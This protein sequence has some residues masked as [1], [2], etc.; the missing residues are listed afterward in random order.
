MNLA[1]EANQVSV[2]QIS[3]IAGQLNSMFLAI[4]NTVRL[5]TRAMYAQVEA[6]RS[7]QEIVLINED[8]KREFQFWISQVD[9]L[10]GKAMWF[11]SSAVRVAYSDASDT[12]YGGYI[13]ELGPNVAA[14]GTWNEIE[15]SQSSA[16]RELI[17]VRN[18]LQSFSSKISGLTVKWFTDNQNVARI[19]EVGSGK[20]HLQ[21]EAL[22]IFYICSSSGITIEPA[23]IP[24]SENDRADYFS[25]IVDKDDWLINPS[26]F[27]WPDYMWEPHSIDRFADE[28]NHQLPRFD[29]KF[30]N[31]KCEAMDAFVRSWDYENTWLCPPFYLIPRVIRHMQSCRAKGS[32]VVPLWRSALFWPLIAP[33]GVHFASFIINWVELPRSKDTFWSGRHSPGLFGKG[34]I[35]FRVLALRIDFRQARFVQSRFCSSFTGCCFKCR[36]LPFYCSNIYLCILLFSF[37]VGPLFDSRCY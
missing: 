8:I 16:M 24:R 1:V 3:S 35:H 17:A 36:Y 13:V 26:I 18:V 22:N 2:R 28:H 5:F 20:R 31:P 27:R 15:V 30:W 21:N 4:G 9:S 14:Q 11:G 32:L 7:W 34:D 12:G 19:Q 25:R 6:R 37:G 29:S 10:N 33:D 23:W